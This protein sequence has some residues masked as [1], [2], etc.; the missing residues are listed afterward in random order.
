MTRTPINEFCVVTPAIR[1]VSKPENLKK[2]KTSPIMT[3]SVYSLNMAAAASSSKKRSLTDMLVETVSRIEKQQ[4][5]QQRLIERMI[6]QQQ[7]VSFDKKH[8]QEF[9]PIWDPSSALVK[10]API[11]PLG[12]KN[13]TNF[14]E[15]FQQLIRSYTALPTQKKS[16]VVRQSLQQSLPDVDTLCDL[17]DTFWQSQSRP[18]V[19]AK[20]DPM[21]GEGCS[22]IECPHK[23]EL[24]RIDEFYKEFLS[25][26]A[27][28]PPL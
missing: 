1:V 22:C 18:P 8:K 25:T 16:D 9:L 6:V 7:A 24:E 23:L 5:E 28:L 19:F 27:N 14:T 4:E 15:A 17:V 21:H 20:P 13:P 2:E 12:E 11:E 3:P 10:P 26:G